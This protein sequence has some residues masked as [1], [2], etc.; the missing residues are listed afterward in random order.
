L[1]AIDSTLARRAVRS[2]LEDDFLWRAERLAVETDFYATHRG[3][4]AF[5]DDHQT[6]LGSAA[7]PWG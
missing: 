6:R 2:D 4:V 7:N 1:R 3:S 5:E